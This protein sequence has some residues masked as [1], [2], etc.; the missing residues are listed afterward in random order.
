VPAADRGASSPILRTCKASAWRE[1][2]V[3]PTCIHGFNVLARKTLIIGVQEGAD[4]AFLRAVQINIVDREECKQIYADR[5][6]V[7]S[8]MVCAGVPE[9]KKA[10]CDGD[11]GGALVLKKSGKQVGIVSWG[12]GCS[13]TKTPGVYANVADKEIHEFIESELEGLGIVG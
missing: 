8:R 4:R 1:S 5:V 3:I 2:I 13:D 11:N 7:T 10:T 12:L 9:G 6:K